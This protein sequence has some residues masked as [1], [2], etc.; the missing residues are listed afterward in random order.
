MIDST[1][2][3]CN[4]DYSYFV[5]NRTVSFEANSQGSITDYLWSFGDGTFAYS[6]NPVKTYA[7][8][9]FYEV[10][11][12]VY[13]EAT[14]CIDEYS[15]VILVR[16]STV[17]SCKADYGYYANNTTFAFKSESRGNIT[18]YFWD[19]GDGS[20]AYTANPTHTYVE[21]DF[22]YVTLSIYDEISGCLD[23]YG[24]MVVV[25]DST[26]NLCNA[27][28]E[29]YTENNEAVFTSLAQGNITNHFW[30]FGDG[31]YS[32]LENPTHV[33]AKPDFYEVC[34]TIY[35]ENTGC[36]DEFCDIVFVVD[37]AQNMCAAD[38][39]VYTESNSVFFTN[40]SQG[41]Y[42]EQFWDF[43]D[44]N[45]SFEKSPSHIYDAP[46][47]YE[48]GL[49]IYD[50][51]SGCIDD[52]YKVVVVVD[53]SVET[54]NARFNFYT[55]GYTAYFDPKAIGNYSQIFW[56]FG[57]GFNSNEENP[58]HTYANPGYYE[59]WL[60]VIDT[61]NGCYDSR[62]K[63]VFIEGETGATTAAKAR[64]S[65]IPQSDGRTVKFYDES[66]GT[67][68]SWY[69]DF[70][71]NTAAGTTQNPTYVYDTN[72][73]YQVNL[74]ITNASGSQD[75]YTDIIAVG[76]VT[77]ASYAYFTYFADLVTSTGH[78]RNASRGNIVSYNWD[79]GDGYGSV[80]ENP[81]HTY[82]DTGYYAVCLTT[83]SASGE[84]KSYCN[85]VRIGN[86]IANPCLFSCVWPGDANN[87]LEANHYDIMTIGLNYGLTGPM[88]DS[89]SIFWTGHFGQN[90]STFQLD[91]TN[92]KHGDCNGDGVINMDDTLAIDQNFAYSHY[93]TPGKRNNSY[94]IYVEWDST[95]TG[96]KATAGK[97]RAR[98]TRPTKEKEDADIY[99]IG[100]EIEIVGG[101]GILFNSIKVEFNG[102]W[103]GTYG[104]DLL[105]FYALDSVKQMIYVGM[106]RTD[107]TN[108]SGGGDLI[109][110]YFE[111]LDGYDINGVSFIATSLGGIDASGLGINIGGSF[112]IDLGPDMEICEGESVMLDAG[113]GFADY[114]WSNEGSTTNL[115]EVTQSG[116]YYVTVTDSAG[117]SA[118]DSI[119]I[120]VNPLPIVDLG[121][122]I[123]SNQPVTLDAGTGFASYE[124]QDGTTTQ[125]YE[126][127]QTGEYWVMVTDANGCQNA[128]TIQVDITTDITDLNTFGN[129]ID[130]Y[131]NPNNGE[132]V[133]VLQTEAIENMQV[134]IVNLQGQKVLVKEFD[135]IKNFNQKI[136]VRSLD[137]GVYYL[138][139]TKGNDYAIMKMIKQ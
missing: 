86:S 36:L 39:R 114:A 74:T 3:F 48:V 47:F 128:D 58:A 56:D 93:Y 68:T 60:S 40:K 96:T 120:Q 83:T 57:D 25:V 1:Q 65:Y 69:W 28:Y 41:T 8:P 131:P 51:T 2:T 84:V 71:N 113:E 29:F 33:Y 98:M 139:V 42:T 63:V 44:G 76:D 24:E 85:D 67:P 137:D 53:E 88:R 31:F 81:S 59:V 132:F 22:Y 78:F 7:S 35:D 90:W 106:S 50:E 82:Q 54:C 9:D 32:T 95:Y 6:A 138:K 66:F 49:T 46:G 115:L 16:D 12:T 103:L 126:V 121:A 111:F 129:N 21:P 99:A 102:S 37:T 14:D 55:E 18:D 94:E 110:I 26:A 11:L 118:V 116:K 130:F 109:D 97:A 10:T 72:N 101:Q 133:L 62:S 17:A 100:Y 4:A 87:D 79:F 34:Y 125:T 70:G 77:N 13:N 135:H 61:A 30:S 89:V 124:W 43:G 64:F 127:T 27:N 119:M 104:E 23:E 105:G 45:Y 73:Y 122:D 108:V 20:Y 107:H 15:E 92:N 91:G 117:T 38:F 136:D 52:K 134:E 80:Q 123:E 5:N 19:F 75:T 112:S